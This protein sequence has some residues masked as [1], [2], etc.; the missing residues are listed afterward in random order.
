M[1]ELRKYHNMVKG[2][3]LQEAIKMIR[4]NEVSQAISLLDLACGPASDLFKWKKL[5]IKDVLALDKDEGAIMEARQRYKALGG[6]SYRFVIADCLN[7][8]ERYARHAR[9]SII[10]SN[11]A[12]HYMMEDSERFPL[13]M[14]AVAGALKPSGVFVGTVLNGDRVEKM[15]NGAQSFSNSLVS[16]TKRAESHIEVDMIDTHY[17]KRGTSVEILVRPEDLIV[18]ALERGLKLVNWT[19]FPDYLSPAAQYSR[20]AA[21]VSG[22]YDIFM[23]VKAR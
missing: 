20:D 15:L 11:F 10:T 18:A 1:E 23:F 13:F 9:W 17:F 2:K 19:R 12:I 8:L 14:D 6:V 16:I 7:R 22:L 4:G 21:T 3:C 5:G